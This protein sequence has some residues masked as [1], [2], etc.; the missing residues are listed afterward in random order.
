MKN[1]PITLVF[2]AS[3]EQPSRLDRFL[4]SA[5][6]TYSRTY[7]HDLIERG[8]VKVNSRQVTKPSLTLKHNDSI[9]VELL[10][11]SYNVEPFAVDFKVLDTQDDFIVI[12]KP[13][14][15]VVHQAHTGD[16]APS[17]VNGLL[18][19]FKEFTAFDDAQ[20][21]GIVHRI[22]KDTSG[23]LLVA[24]HHIAQKELSA[25]FKQR[26]IKKT[27]LAVVHG[28]PNQQGTIDLPIGRSFKERHKMSHAGFCSRS[29]HTEYTVLARYA[30][31]ALVAVNLITGRTHQIRVHFAAIGHPLVGDKT[32]GKPS[33]LINRQAL[34]AWKMAFEYKGKMHTYHNILPADMKQLLS[35]LNTKNDSEK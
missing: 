24:R 2:N 9:T 22:D 23:L 10:I 25:L 17:L 8:L 34:H 6:P 3:D 31:T 15:L 26:A 35:Q 33:P 7:F 13:A 19:H 14:G 16:T 1:E 28:H 29:A 20:R 27:Y 4:F 12:D 30:D 11:K 21:P 5:L 18:Y 32:Y